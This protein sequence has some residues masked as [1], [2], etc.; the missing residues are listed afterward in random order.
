MNDTDFQ[1]IESELSITL[2]EYYK[3]AMSAD[4][5]EGDEYSNDLMYTADRVISMNNLI[6]EESPDWP[7]NM[8]MIS[9]PSD[10]GV[11]FLDLNLSP[12]PVFYNYG[13][14]LLGL[15]QA[16][17]FDQ[18]FVP[19]TADRDW[20]HFVRMCHTDAQ[21]I[22]DDSQLIPELEAEIVGGRQL[23]HLS[24]GLIAAALVFLGR[25]LYFR[26][27]ILLAA[28]ILLLFI[29]LL[30]FFGSSSASARAQL[31]RIRASQKQ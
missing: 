2:P 14:Q 16:G 22:A 23:R 7:R 31:E 4:L 18:L 30:S 12:S 1:R 26:V 27:C 3:W 5:D 29:G 28:C 19:R 8:F 20:D 11:H 24:M 9:E 6:R 21:E 15:T 17:T 10:R 13:F 25:W